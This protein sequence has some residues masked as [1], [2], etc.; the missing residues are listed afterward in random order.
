M[1]SEDIIQESLEGQSSRQSEKNTY[2][3]LFYLFRFRKKDKVNVQPKEHT[4]S[5]PDERRDQLERDMKNNWDELP[6]TLKRRKE[7]VSQAVLAE[8]HSEG[9]NDQDSNKQDQGSCSDTVQTD[10]VSEYSEPSSSV[11]VQDKDNIEID[12]ANSVQPSYSIKTETSSS[13][14]STKNENVTDLKEEKDSAISESSSDYKDLSEEKKENEL[15]TKSEINAQEFN[16]LKDNLKDVLNSN[17]EVKSTTLDVEQKNVIKLLSKAVSDDSLLIE[18]SSSSEQV[19]SSSS[20]C[21]GDNHDSGTDINSPSSSTSGNEENA[22]ERVEEDFGKDCDAKHLLE[23]V[24]LETAPVYSSIPSDKLSINSK[25][26]ND[27]QIL[28]HNYQ[29]ISEKP[30]SNS[31]PQKNKSL[32]S[33][34]AGSSLAS[35]SDGTLETAD[36]GTYEEVGAVMIP[37]AEY[38][39]KERGKSMLKLTEDDTMSYYDSVV[40]ESQMNSK[41][42]SI[43]ATEN[44]DTREYIAMRIKSKSSNDCGDQGLPDFVTDGFVYTQRRHSTSE[45]NSEDPSLTVAESIY[46]G[47]F[48]CVVATK[49]KRPL[50]METLNKKPKTMATIVEEPATSEEA[51]ACCDGPKLSVREILRRFEELGGRVPPAGEGEEKSATLREIQETLRCLEEKVRMY[52][53]KSALQGDEDETDEKMHQKAVPRITADNFQHAAAVKQNANANLLDGWTGS[54]ALQQPPPP[55]QQPS[56]Q[57]SQLHHHHSQHHHH[58]SAQ[59]QSQ[60]LHSQ[61]VQ[62]QQMQQQQV[63]R[64]SPSSLHQ[65]QSLTSSQVL[66][67]HSGSPVQQNE[68]PEYVGQHDGKHS[69]LQ[70]A[71][72]HFR[73]SPEKFE[74]LKTADGSISGSLKVIESLKSKKGKGKKGNKENDWTWKEQVDLVKFTPVLIEQSLLR[75]ETN[76]LNE[77]AIE[78]FL[79]VMRYMGDMPMI[80]DVTEV[81]C[82]YT[83]LMH[84][85]KH[86]S[87]RDEVYCQL[88]KQ[89]T[90]NKS[91][92]PDSCQRGWRLFSIVAAYF[93]CSDTLKP[94]L[95]K[96]LETAAYD[97]RRAYHGTATVCLH[98]LRKTFKYGGRKNVPSVEEITAISAGRNSKRQIYRL[99][100]GT[101][102]VINTKSTTVVQ[103]VIEEICSVINVQAPHEMEEFSLYCIVEGDTFTMPLAREEYILDVTTE[104]HKNQQVFYLIFC[105]SVWHFPLRLDS[106]LYIEVVFN[107]IAPDYLEGLLLVMPGEQLDQDVIYDIAK[108]AALLHRAADM[109]HLPSMKETKFLLPKP[110]LTV[111]DVKPAQWVNMVQSNWREVESLQTIQAKA[112]VLDILSKWP[113]FGSSF[114][115]VKRISDP[116]E[117]AD[118]ILALNR[119]G[120]HFID[121]VTHETLIHYPFSEVISTRKV[122]SEDGTLFLD[123]K[124]GN[125]MQQRITRLQTDQAHEISRL[126]RQYITMEQRLRS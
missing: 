67:P 4:Q 81:K 27:S 117:R 30:I 118:H 29:D 104:L 73:Q 65:Q 79:S 124:C 94:Y 93:V 105:R 88:M 66:Q 45:I 76:E 87:L 40:Q 99:P 58:M 33:T 22:K 50:V 21:E 96:Y 54:R 31:E 37:R 42:D 70:F 24:E 57:Q 92:K 108:M 56:P 71:M 39:I 15:T 5:S 85:H 47:K 44:C 110:A 83:I 95:F 75:L 6:A 3:K 28:K 18:S 62:H 107:Q 120:V 82:V 26:P 38:S 116:K 20:S 86:E 63:Q 89:T 121:L 119:H 55:Q 36:L 41:T 123:M 23:N 61:H 17:T 10:V 101:E 84:C 1:P 114:F 11:Y 52:E 34:S 103:D 115:A 19:S 78:C 106:H 72:L 125:L 51:E 16:E 53:E 2:Q 32:P 77:L 122:K 98:N 74:M 97:K 7:K 49:W 48:P 80:P 35:G 69:L 102:R 60:P 113:L 90:N 64:Q 14:S 9:G 111:R 68:P 8:F 43:N 91:T 12:L 126:I 112:Q 25:Q 46:R 13:A 59:Q 109:K 100:G